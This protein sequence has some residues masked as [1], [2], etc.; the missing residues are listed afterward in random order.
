MKH[1]H[2]HQYKSHIQASFKIL[3]T[4]VKKT[5]NYIHMQM[6]RRRESRASTGRPVTHAAINNSKVKSQATDLS[7][8]ITWKIFA[9]YMSRNS[10]SIYHHRLNLIKH[11]NTMTNQITVSYNHMHMPLYFFLYVVTKQTVYHPGIH[12]Y[13]CV[14]VWPAPYENLT[15]RSPVYDPKVSCV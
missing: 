1:K 7:A 4:Q 10:V 5:T 9:L 2:V 12:I 13:H 6:L 8:M 14:V 3:Y 11:K 15:R